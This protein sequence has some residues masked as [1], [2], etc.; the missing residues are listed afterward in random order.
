M[1]HLMPNLTVGEELGSVLLTAIVVPAQWPAEGV[2]TFGLLLMVRRPG[3]AYL[4]P[5]TTD[6]ECQALRG[7]GNLKNDQAQETDPR[8]GDSTPPLA[9]HPKQNALR[10]Q[11]PCAE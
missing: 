8:V 5:A 1:A 3:G 11:S 4:L 7:D 2:A 9:N 6:D 10:R